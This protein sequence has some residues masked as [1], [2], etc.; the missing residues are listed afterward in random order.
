M[1][2]ENTYAMHNKVNCDLSWEEYWTAVR[3]VK[4]PTGQPKFPNLIK[5]VQILAT[6]PSSNAAMERIFRLQLA[7]VD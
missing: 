2:S 5:F 6:F 4:N 1:N 7:K 3:D